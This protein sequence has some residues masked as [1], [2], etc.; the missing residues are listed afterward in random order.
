MIQDMVHSVQTA[1]SDSL[2]IYGDDLWV[3][4]LN[5]PP[6]GLGQGNGAAPGTWALLSSPMLNAIRDKGHG[7]VFTC[8]ISKRSFR[9]IGY[10]FVDDL[11]IVQMAP[12]PNTPTEELAWQG[13]Q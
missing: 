11:T 1:Y 13:Q 4:K 3:V 8:V 6:Q 2:E 10:C 12:S 5:P 9:L 7:A